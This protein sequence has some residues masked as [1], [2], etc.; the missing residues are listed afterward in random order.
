MRSLPT[1]GRTVVSDLVLPLDNI[2]F[3]NELEYVCT[4]PFVFRSR[5]KAP[6]AF[7]KKRWVRILTKI[8]FRSI[9]AY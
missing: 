6:K 3:H 1:V 4:F 5:L 9:F 2:F 7:V 8:S